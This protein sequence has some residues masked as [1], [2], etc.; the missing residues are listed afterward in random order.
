MTT[1]T[2]RETYEFISRQTNDPI[3]EWKTCKISGQPFPIFQSDL[4]FYEKISPVFN[5]KKYQVPFPTLCPEERQ[6]RR[7]SFRNERN[8]YRRSSDFSGKEIISIYTPDA[9]YKVY[10]Q[11]ER[12]SDS[13][14]PRSYGRD[15]DFS[16]T[17]LEQ[18]RELCLAVP[19]PAIQNMKSE[20]C[21]YTNYSAENK[22]CYL[23]MGVG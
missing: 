17:F 13:R 4:D 23:A 15:F 14:D 10:A 18:Y 22:N 16:K 3:V 12:R 6:R 11:E 2:S 8:L 9:P 7:V 19:R 5:G 20:N 1:Y 21:A